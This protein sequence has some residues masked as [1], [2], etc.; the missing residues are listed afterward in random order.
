MLPSG[1]P[2]PREDRAPTALLPYQQAWNAD[3]SRVKVAE[4]GRRTGFT[5]GE[6]AEDA[7]LAG[8]AHGMDVFYIG[9]SKDMAQEFIDDCAMWA[10]HFDIAAG[11]A[12]EFLFEDSDGTGESRHIQAFRIKFAS[13]YK[14]EALSSRPR[15]LRGKQGKIIIDEAAFH[16]DLA[17]L[18]KAALAMLVWGGMVVVIS[19]H[20][21]DDHPF[22][23]LVNE[24]RA[25]RKNY[26]LHRVT[27]DDAIQAGLYKRVCLRQGIGWDPAAQQEWRDAIVKD[28]GDDADEELF[29]IPAAGSGT[30]FTRGLIE[31]CMRPGIPILRYSQSATFAEQDDR[32]RYAE[33]RD[34]CEELLAPLLAAL[35]FEKQ[36]F[37]GEDFGRYCDLTAMMPLVEK[38]NANLE[39]P[40]LVE[41]QNVPF[42]QQEQIMR[43]IVDRL[44]RFRAGAFDATGNGSYLA[45]RA[46]Q[47]YGAN[48]IAQIMISESFY[49][50]NMPRYHACFEDGTIV[51][52]RD[53]DVIADH[54]AI[55]KIKGTPKLPELK[56][57][58]KDNRKRHGD[59]A[60]AGLMAV[61]AAYV[62]EPGGDAGSVKSTGA[63]AREMRADAAM[64][65]TRPNYKAF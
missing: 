43:Y 1:K 10:R 30:Y 21:G 55:K 3:R 9:Y 34:W 25:G 49:R 15:N 23:E 62:M 60:I 61:Y 42:Q 29:C 26:S 35:E 16:D 33:V 28:Y 63:G 56:N 64:Y 44:P 41:L 12:E 11:E 13:G 19:T 59:T 18:L 65:H 7:V 51:L 14:I 57:V 48:R 22:N 45:E 47:F 39:C 54:R 6:A 38:Q 24:I 27:F 2:E 40:F 17:G 4:K 53:A 58:G 32:T 36:T 46:M 31:K 37:F 5:W 52:P 20:N 50:E 8:S